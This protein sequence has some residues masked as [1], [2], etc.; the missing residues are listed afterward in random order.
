MLIAKFLLLTHRN[1][2][3][4][5]KHVSCFCFGLPYYRLFMGYPV[6]FPLFCEPLVRECTAMWACK[7]YHCACATQVHSH[8]SFLKLFTDTRSKAGHETCSSSWSCNRNKNLRHTNAFL[9]FFW[10]GGAGKISGILTSVIFDFT[11]HISGTGRGQTIASFLYDVIAGIK[12]ISAS[13]IVF[14]IAEVTPNT[15]SC[16]KN[17]INSLQ[18]RGSVELKPPKWSKKSSGI[19]VKF[20]L[21]SLLINSG[22][23]KAPKNVS[24]IFKNVIKI[25]LPSGTGI[26]QFFKKSL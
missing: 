11:T 8:L 13:L 16:K 6:I 10:R 18:L 12:L 7:L 15:V 20:N 17:F 19:I 5:L 24:R 3:H 1:V 2:Y 23:I 9:L 21:H 4:F 26:Y 22:K 25:F 14:R